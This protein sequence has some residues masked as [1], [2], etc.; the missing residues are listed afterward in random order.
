MKNQL[1]TINLMKT[2]V[3]QPLIITESSK[4]LHPIETKQ[5]TCNAIQ[6]IG[7]YPKRAFTKRDY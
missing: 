5:S 7:L 4:I 3:E 2:K 1:N 6:L